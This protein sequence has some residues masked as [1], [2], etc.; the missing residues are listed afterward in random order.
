MGAKTLRQQLYING[1]P[2]SIRAQDKC[3]GPSYASGAGFGLHHPRN[4]LAA[5]A[6]IFNRFSIYDPYI[7]TMVDCEEKPGDH[8]D[9][10]RSLTGG[11]ASD[12]DGGYLSRLGALEK[13]LDEAMQA[14]MAPEKVQRKRQTSILE[15]VDSCRRSLMG[16]PAAKA[17][18]RIISTRSWRRESDADIPA[19]GVVGGRPTAGV[20]RRGSGRTETYQEAGIETSHPR[21]DWTIAWDV[22]L[23]SGQKGNMVESLMRAL[24]PATKAL[25]NEGCR[26]LADLVLVVLKVQQALTVAYSKRFQA[27]PLLDHYQLRTSGACYNVTGVRSC[28]IDGGEACPKADADPCWRA[29]TITG[30]TTR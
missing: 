29:G 15:I 30:E 26:P 6:A 9:L 17:K 1:I 8:R 18:P 11:T 19:R 21:G 10:Y 27:C 7:Q 16:E 3:E 14:G 22:S 13:V 25:L 4:G 23:V 5:G 20:G 2:R 12:G 24:V 28:S